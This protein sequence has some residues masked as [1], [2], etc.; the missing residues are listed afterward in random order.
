MNRSTENIENLG[1]DFIGVHRADVSP[2]FYK[3]R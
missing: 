1:D 3:S 2:T